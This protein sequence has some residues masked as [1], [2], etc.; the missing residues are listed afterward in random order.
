MD[1]ISEQ[2]RTEIF[3]LEEYIERAEDRT[4]AARWTGQLLDPLEQVGDEL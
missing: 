4:L 1:E 3:T 2:L